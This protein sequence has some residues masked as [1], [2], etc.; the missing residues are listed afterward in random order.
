MS[1]DKSHPFLLHLRKKNGMDAG[2]P[3]FKFLLSLNH[4]RSLIKFLWNPKVTDD[5]IKIHPILKSLMMQD[6]STG[7][8]PRLPIK[9]VAVTGRASVRFPIGQKFPVVFRIT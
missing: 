8:R 1:A 3:A 5:M 2:C 7:H 6:S 4:S 9:D